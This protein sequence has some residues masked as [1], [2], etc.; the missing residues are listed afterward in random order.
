MIWIDWIDWEE[1]KHRS[2][3]SQSKVGIGRTAGNRCIANYFRLAVVS[4]QKIMRQEA[5]SIHTFVSIDTFCP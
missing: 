3:L 5:N 4:L 2:I 1:L